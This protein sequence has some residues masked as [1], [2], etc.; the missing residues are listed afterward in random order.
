MIIGRC[1]R[2]RR[3]KPKTAQQLLGQLPAARVSPGKAFHS[4]GIDYCGPFIVKER[5]GRCKSSSKGWVAV[6]ICQATR[7]VH[8]D[9][10]SELTTAAFMAAF[11][12]LCGR[13][14]TPKL[15]S[16]DNGTTFVGADNYLRQ[17]AKSLRAASADSLFAVE[18]IEWS[19]IPPGAPHQGGLWEAA[20]KSAKHHLTR[21]AG[22]RWLTF[23]EMSTVLVDIEACLNSRPLTP[24]TND[25]RDLQA[26]T[27]GHFLIGQPIVQLQGTRLLHIPEARL[28]RWRL[29]EQI[30][31]DF[32]Q[33]WQEEYLTTLTHR[34]KWRSASR[35]LEVG[36]LVLIMNELT[37]RTRW[38][39]GRVSEM[40]PGADGRVRVV[41]VRH[42]FGTLVRPVQK[43]V[44][45][46]VDPPAAIEG[47]QQ[48]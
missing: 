1:I 33:R 29:L 40:H 15:I 28:D 36:E 17:I 31:Q 39:M 43:L 6:I 9:I 48:E 42:Q 3:C 41:T 12:R 16:T 44:P 2:C 14:G 34:T 22:G 25:P 32:W 7:A 19:F 18:E 24:L 8:L 21:V 10:V 27:P 47:V 45:L 35:N 23:E 5:K 38:A 26:L 13:R 20:V 4:I 46:P 30:Q 11:R 37:P